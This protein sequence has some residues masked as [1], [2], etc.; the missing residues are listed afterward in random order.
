MIQL[1]D[2][3]NRFKKNKR[4][5]RGRSS[6]KGKTSGRGHKGQKSRSGH[7]KLP[8]FFEGGQM[9]LTQRLP[10]QKGFK[11]ISKLV[12]EIVNLDKLNLF[13]NNSL[14]NK[15]LLFKN[16]LIKNSANKVKILGDGELNRKIKIEADSF[17]K[18]ALEKIK[19]IGGQAI[20][21]SEGIKNNTV[22]DKN[23]NK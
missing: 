14:V 7:K 6:G 17:S 12:W 2:F 16:K 3:K 1:S 9:P 23:K 20:Y 15:E 13:P 4:V 10:K 18:K 21:L 8:P 11:R 19:K 5:G 22:K